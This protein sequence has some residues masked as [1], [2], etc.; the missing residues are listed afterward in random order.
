MNS[1]KPD[2]ED[3]IDQALRLRLRHWAALKSPP[4]NGRP[5]LLK[6]A[7]FSTAQSERTVRRNFLIHSDLQLNWT[8]TYLA[9]DKLLNLRLVC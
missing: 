7:L 6:N 3:Q 5:R 1:R 8:A 4:K 2:I 9:G